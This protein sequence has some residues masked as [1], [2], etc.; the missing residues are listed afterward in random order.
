MNV[1]GYREKSFFYQRVEAKGKAEGAAYALFT[2]IDA[3]SIVLSDEERPRVLAAREMSEIEAWIKR[4]ITAM[5]PAEVFA[6]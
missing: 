4:A 1:Q 3:R 2:I 5:S 6:S